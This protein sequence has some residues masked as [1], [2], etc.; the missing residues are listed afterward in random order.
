MVDADRHYEP[1]SALSRLTCGYVARRALGG[2]QGR[3]QR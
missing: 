1:V 3:A 2:L